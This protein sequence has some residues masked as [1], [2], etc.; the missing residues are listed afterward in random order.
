M[1]EYVS[2]MYDTNDGSSINT[3]IAGEGLDTP[4]SSAGERLVVLRV[5]M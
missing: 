2:D 3:T 4:S 1:D 5:P